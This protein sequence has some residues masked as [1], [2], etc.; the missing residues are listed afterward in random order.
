MQHQND[1]AINLDNIIETLLDAARLHGE[2]S[3]SDHEV[4]DLQDHLRTMWRLL[5]PAMRVAFLKLETV[6]ASLENESEEG[7]QAVAALLNEQLPAIPSG[8]VLEEMVLEFPGFLDDSDVN[9]GDLVDWVSCNL[10]L[11]G[12]QHDRAAAD[13]PSDDAVKG[14]LLR[15]EIRVGCWGA[16]VSHDGSSIVGTL[17]NIKGRANVTQ[18]RRTAEGAFELAFLGTDTFEDESE[19]A[20]NAR[21]EMIFLDEDG[22][23]YPASEV[24][25]V[26][27]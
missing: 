4:G 20:L 2:N 11:F 5:T 10:D 21:G 23:E 1:K 8:S 19:T 27:L 14:K 3:E 17:E 25:L 15:D 6:Q 7:H 18:A 16:L 22:R 26:P 12:A 24:K 9:G 13:K